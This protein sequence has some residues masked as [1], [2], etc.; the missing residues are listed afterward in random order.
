MLDFR[1]VQETDYGRISSF[2]Q[3]SDE[4]F[5]LFPHGCFPLTAKQLKKSV[6][7]RTDSTVV[8][9]NGEVAGFANFITA[10]KG[11]SCN[12]GNVILSPLHRGKGLGEALISEMCRIGREKYRV[13]KMKI[14]CFNQNT[15]GLLLYTK[16]GF[17]PQEITMWE[18]Q[19]KQ[20]VAL[21]HLEREER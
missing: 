17:S 4:L 15:V 3:S 10:D 8:E 18:K 9:W 14:S 20:R 11:E 16:L 19:D 6:E 13:K 2:P 7:S 5:Y 12:I 1:P 21:L